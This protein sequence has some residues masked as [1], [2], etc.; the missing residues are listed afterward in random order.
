MS[1]PKT[2]HAN[3]MQAQNQETLASWS[4]LFVVNVSEKLSDVGGQ[5]VQQD[6]GLHFTIIDQ[7]GCT[8]HIIIICDG[9]GHKG[10]IISGMVTTTFYQE[11]SNSGFYDRFK[12]NPTETAVSM[13][14]TAQENIFRY[15]LESLEEGQHKYK[16]KDGNIYSSAPILKGGTTATVVMVDE[17]G[18]VFTM[19]VADSEAWMIQGS[20]AI[21]LTADHLPDTPSEYERIQSEYSSTKHLYDR[22]YYM[23][24]HTRGDDIF[25]LTE[26][27]GYYVKNVNEDWAA[28]VVVDVPLSGGGVFAQKL[29]FTR[30]IGDE[31]MRKGGVIETP[32]VS[33]H[34]ASDSSIILVA[35]DGFWDN[36]KTSSLVDKTC[37][38]A[39]TKDGKSMGQ[40]WFDR[41]KKENNKNF[42]SERDNMMGYLITM[43]KI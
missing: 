29:A 38:D 2:L 3:P 17:E 23:K 33:T 27:K 35:S 18:S 15:M 34:T 24:P 12:Q 13:F 30:S 7:R 37:E 6:S 40:Q 41:V 25:P 4:P 16:I 21:Q 36:I 5:V 43:Q 22:R 28:V 10:E 42:G 32:S 1:S 9:H 19:N 8:C 20:S 31:N 26:K 39:E 14:K 11:M